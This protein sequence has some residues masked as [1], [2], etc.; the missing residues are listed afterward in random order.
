[1][2]PNDIAV[3]LVRTEGPVNLGLI[4]RNCRNLGINDLRLVAP[5]CDRNSDDARKFANKPAIFCSPPRCIQIYPLPCMTAAWLLV[6]ALERAMSAPPCSTCPP[7][8]PF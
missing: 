5:L 2:L 4:A 1:V 7:R 8:M 3:I 6:R